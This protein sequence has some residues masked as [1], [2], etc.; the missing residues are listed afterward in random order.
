MYSPWAGPI[1]LTKK[2]K[3]GYEKYLN[4]VS[5]PNEMV[6]PVYEKTDISC[7]SNSK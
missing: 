6:N 2:A 1:F 4:K 5:K 3:K 7:T